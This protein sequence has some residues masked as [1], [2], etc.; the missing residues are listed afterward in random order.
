MFDWFRTVPTL[1]P[2]NNTHLTALAR[3]TLTSAFTNVKEDGTEER[4]DISEEFKAAVGKYKVYARGM[5]GMQRTRMWM[6]LHKS[7][8]REAVQY[9]LEFCASVALPMEARDN[10]QQ[11]TVFGTT[12]G[13]P[14]F[15]SEREKNESF[16]SWMKRIHLTVCARDDVLGEVASLLKDHT[17]FRSAATGAQASVGWCA[18]T[19]ECDKRPTVDDIK[20]MRLKH[21]EKKDVPPPPPPPEDEEAVLTFCACLDDDD[22]EEEEEENMTPVERD[23]LHWILYH[24]ELGVWNFL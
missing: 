13:D 12:Q 20:A 22:E 3:L 9:E 18:I 2:L 14:L 17:K 6:H 8:W 10:A 16:Y 11:C 23:D 5:C 19:F 1:A 15:I 24:T 7:T 21:R 4:V